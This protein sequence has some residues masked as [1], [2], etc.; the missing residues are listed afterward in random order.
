MIW[1]SW[2]QQRLEALLGAAVLAALAA[3]LVLTGR[4]IAAVYDHARLAACSPRTRPTDLL[5]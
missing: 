4:H 3:L 2:R 1:L 5:R